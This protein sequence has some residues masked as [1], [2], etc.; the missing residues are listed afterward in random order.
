MFKNEINGD[1]LRK[2][3]RAAV[4]SCIREAKSE[5]LRRYG[6]GK[7]NTR[8]AGAQNALFEFAKNMYGNIYGISVG[9]FESEDFETFISEC[10]L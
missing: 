6:S 8:L 5:M 3:T 10:H 2:Y 9:M 7:D 4:A 1:Q